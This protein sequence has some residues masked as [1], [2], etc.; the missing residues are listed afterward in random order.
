[1]ALMASGGTGL[2]SGPK[3]AAGG[4]GMSAT[5]L[6]QWVGISSCSRLIRNGALIETE[7]PHQL[8]GQRRLAGTA[9]TGEVYRYMNFDQIPE[10]VEQAATVEM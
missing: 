4:F 9:G 2:P 10:F 8:V 6:Y 1:M 3:G 7:A 5:T